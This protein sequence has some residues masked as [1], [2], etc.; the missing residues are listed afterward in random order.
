[1]AVSLPACVVQVFFLMIGAMVLLAYWRNR[2]LLIRLIGRLRPPRVLVLI[3][4]LGAILRLSYWLLLSRSPSDEGIYLNQAWL[5]FRGWTPYEDFL[6]VHP[7]GYHYLTAAAYAVFG[8]SV[9]SAKLWPVIFSILSLVAFT[10]LARQLLPAKQALFSVSLFA[11][12]YGVVSMTATALLYDG[13]VLFG[14]IGIY[15]YFRSLQEGRHRFLL[16]SGFSF[17]M[18]AYFRLYAVIPLAVVAFMLARQQRIKDAAFLGG[19]FVALGFTL[20]LPVLSAE[21]VYGLFGYHL[22]KP[23]LEVGSLLLDAGGVILGAYPLVLVFGL[24]GVTSSSWKKEEKQVRE[25]L[26][27]YLILAL[28]AVL[29]SRHNNPL[30]YK[31]YFMVAAIPLSLTAGYALDFFSERRFEVLFIALLLLGAGKAHVL[32]AWA[33]AAWDAD[34]R[35]AAAYVHAHTRNGQ[36][37]S[38]DFTAT[39]FVSFLARRD[40][41]PCVHERG[42][43]MLHSWLLTDEYKACLFGDADYIVY[44]EVDAP[45][46]TAGN[47]CFA[48]AESHTETM[49]QLIEGRGF[50][51]AARFG[52]I[53]IYRD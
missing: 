11:I 51:P 39:P 35:Q 52:T 13:M 26:G 43:N 31:T 9:Y 3:V 47:G 2:G 22:Q 41:P 38:G 32:D 34:V 23:G 45:P 6:L 21:S 14:L 44:R 42:Y 50:R 36:Y 17:A 24:L 37:V 30:V 46:D 19:A 49:K 33:R 20:Y 8:V 28:L 10:A 4:C 12:S 5:L 1:M 16:F 25:F 29:L 53:V 15:Y 18:S 7:P 27:L 40:F 48:C